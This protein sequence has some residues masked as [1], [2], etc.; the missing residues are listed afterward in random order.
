MC[1]RD[2]PWHFMTTMQR[3]DLVM[4]DFRFDALTRV[5]ATGR[6]RRQVMRAL[7]GLGAV[8]G[9]AALTHG[10]EAARRGYPGPGKPHGPSVPGPCTPFCSPGT[11]GMPNGCGGTCGCSN[12]EDSCI[13]Q[14]CA[15][16][17]DGN[18]EC[19]QC[20]TDGAHQGCFYQTGL[21]CS[22]NLDCQ[23][24]FGDGVC[25]ELSGRKLCLLPGNGA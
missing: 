23:A 8:A 17:C 13:F 15:P 25:W 5:L 18:P 9:G 24:Q 1:I 19:E 4:E 10:A 16:A 3:R 11:C 21:S 2:S 7:I 22:D 6:S 14:S 12:A 20:L